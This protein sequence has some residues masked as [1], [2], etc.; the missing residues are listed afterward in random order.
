MTRI[1]SLDGTP[2][3]NLCFGTMQ[4]GGAADEATS[5]GMFDA[6]RAAGITFFDTAHVY[7]GGAS[8]RILGALVA[9]ERE[10]LIVATKAAYSGGASRANILS[11][12][13]ESRARLSMDVIDI[14]YMHRWDA[15]TP[16]EETFET[17]AR[18][19]SDGVV[20][21]LAVSNYAAWQVMKAQAVAARLG[22]RIDMMQPM[23]NL[24]KRQAEVELLPMAA[25]QG[26]AVAPYSPLGGGLLTGKYAGR[27]GR[28][29]L[30]DDP[31]YAARYGEDWMHR[32][33]EGLGE[34]ADQMGIAAATLAVAWAM[35]HPHVTAP[36]VSARS[37]VQLAPS[38]AASEVAMDAEL[39][40]RISQ[41]SRRPPPATDRLEEAGVER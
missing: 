36:I 30:T 21:F 9:P 41:L 17:L 10:S 25:D 18:L 12:I 2:L 8:E 26:I 23:Y 29:R 31:R 24:V 38:L 15:E 32:A 20:R 4:F 27:G 33:A 39:R 6:C 11:S 5:R 34:I 13:D 19:Q 14:L 7:T 28:G 22:T 1:A 3:S 16:L 35:T 40:A 37:A